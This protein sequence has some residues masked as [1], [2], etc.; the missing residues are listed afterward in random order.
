MDKNTQCTE[1]VHGFAAIKISKNCP[2]HKHLIQKTDSELIKEIAIALD[3]KMS[4]LTTIEIKIRCENCHFFDNAEWVCRINPP[5]ITKDGF[6]VN[7]A[8]WP[9]VLRNEW[10]GQFVPRQEIKPHE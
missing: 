4:D 6:P 7:S 1:C 5:V 3:I 2:I 8:K 10:C 9:R